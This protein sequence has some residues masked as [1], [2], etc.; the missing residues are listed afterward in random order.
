MAENNVE[1]TKGE[2]RRSRI[3]WWVVVAFLVQI[4]AWTAWFIIAKKH[5]VE[6]VPLVSE[7]A[8]AETFALPS[9]RIPLFA[10]MR[11]IGRPA[12]FTS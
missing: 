12:S 7:Y 10:Y 3:W 4:A 11:P 2:A 9:F 1:N 6:E 5:A 8:P